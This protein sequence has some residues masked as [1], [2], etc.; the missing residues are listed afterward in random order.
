MDFETLK[1]GASEQLAMYPSRGLFHLVRAFQFVVVLSCTLFCQA[2]CGPSSMNGMLKP[3]EHDACGS[4]RDRFDVG[5]LDIGAGYSSTRYGK[6][7][8]HVNIGT[9]CTNSRS[10]CFPSTLPGFSSKEYEHRAAALEASGSQSDCQLPDKSTR[11]SGW[12]SNQSWSSDH[13]MFELLKGGIVSCSLNFKEDINEVSTIRADSSNQN[14]FSFS[15]GSSINQKCKSFRPERNS[16]LTKTCS[17]D[18]S[19]SFSV[20]I[21]PN[22]LDW[23]QKYLYLPSLAFLTVANTCNDSILH[24]YEPF[25]TDVQFYPCNSS[26]ALLG[27]GE[28]ASI[29]FVYFPRWLGLSSAHLI[30]QTSAGG[31]LVHAKGFAIE[32]PYGIQPILG[33]D[34]SSSGRWT[35]NLSLFNPFDETIHVEEVTAWMQVSLGQTSHYTEVI[36]S[37]EKFQ[38][39]N[40]LGLA[41]VRDQ[42]VVK[43]GQVGVPLLAIRPHGNWEIGPQSS[44]AVIEIDVS[45]ESEG[46]IFGAFCMQLLRSSQDKSDTVMIPLEAELDG[47]AAYDDLSGSISAFLEPLVPCDASETV[48]VALSLRNAASH[49]LN[50]MEVSEVSDRK[51]FHIQYMEGL[52]LFPGTITQVALITCSQ[53]HVELSDSP[54]E[55]SNIYWSCKLLILT[56]DSSSPRIEIPC[57]DITYYCSRH[58]KDPSIGFE[59]QSEKV[60]SGYMMSGSLG[61]GMHSPSQ[62]KAL[63]PAEADELVLENWKSQGT[64]CGMSVLDD[65]EIFFPM[66]EVGSHHSKWITVT[67]PSPQPVVMQLILNSGEIIDECSAPDGFTQ[68]PSSSFVFDESSGPAKYGFSMAESALT[69][70]YVH[71]YGRASFGPISF[72]PSNRCSWRSSALVRNNLSGVEWLTLRGFG[73]SLSLVLLEGSEPVESVEFNLNLPI[74]LN[75]SP[76]N[77]LVHL[78]E[79]I[80]A[81]SQPLSKEL[82][83]KNTGD[84]PFEVR[85]IKVSGTECGMDGFMVHTCNGFALEPGESAKLLISYQYDFSA[86]MIHRDLELSL[87]AGIYVIPMKASL[88]F[89]MLN[90]CKKSVFWMRVKKSPVA[91]FFVFTLIFLV[92]CWIFSQVIAL[93]SQDDLCKSERSSIAAALRK[94]GKTVLTHHNQGNGK[95][96]VSSEVDSLLRSV[97]DE[98]ISVQACV[99]RHPDGQD[100]IPGQGMT[101]QLVGPTFENHK[102]IDDPLDNRKERA[103]PSSLPSKSVAIYNSNTIETSQ[104]GNLTV[105]TGNEK[106]RRRRKRKGAASKFT[107]QFEVSS[108]QSGNSTPSSPLSP[109]ASVTPKRTW[110]RAPDMEQTIETKCPFTQEADRLPEKDEVFGSDTEVNLLEHQ[111]SARHCSNSLFLPTPEQPAASR[112]TPTKPVLLPSATFP[113]LGRP[114]PDVLCSSPFLASTSAVAPHARAPGSKLYNQKAKE[115]AR[116]GDEYTYDIWG[117]H[118]SGL[119][120]RSKDVTS[121]M[122][123]PT[124]LHDNVYDSE[125]FFVRGPQSLMTMSKSVSFGK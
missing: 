2:T 99:R 5:F 103:F 91:V 45:I 65:H 113:C 39:S 81:C 90:I 55:V 56:N 3:V 78:E 17:F 123:N 20:E 105:K 109:V 15:R 66:V 79:T 30:L 48:V 16:E 94:A 68:P 46:K 12:M 43:K 124:N 114:S 64:K 53:L 32:S 34:V 118:L 21:K 88:P 44:E 70:A 47:K 67:N 25:S 27:P 112:K 13:G 7:M 101:A 26:E 69:E 93:G 38:G 74:P 87:D 28:V 19:S 111:V 10:F 76:P 29:C 125:S 4:Y 31:F 100:G 92:F 49:L 104:Q 33:L 40:D 98:K 35:K 9:V 85:K 23:G 63:D 51:S 11:D 42:L 122:S 77:T 59:Y 82:Y 24:V 72:Q 119:H 6:P 86:A 8:T 108:S 75:A 110:Q 89:S 14:D 22:V 107:G 95:L 117:D 97:G 116:L 84:L 58:Q 83:A 18:G 71:P 61:S 62:I 121:M 115:K 60:E 54:P 52:L 102:Q 73:G 41:N 96:S 36:C 1:I 50:V 106:G 57:Q 120:L 80:Y 37:L